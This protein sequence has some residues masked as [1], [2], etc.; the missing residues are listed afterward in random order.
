MLGGASG[1]R[2]LIVGI[3]RHLAKQSS[4]TEGRAAITTRTRT[5]MVR[6]VVA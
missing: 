4:A 3:P 6:S 2:L 5:H 1:D